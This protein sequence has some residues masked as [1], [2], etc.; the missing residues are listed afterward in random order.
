MKE[1]VLDK[2]NCKKERAIDSL[3]IPGYVYF[4]CLLWWYEMMRYLFANSF[5]VNFVCK[6]IP[7]GLASQ[8]HDI[9]K[10]IHADK[11]YWF[12][13]LKNKINQR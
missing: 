9:F 12:C 11:T 6:K 8:G 2:P 3:E 5:W 7:S 13:W 4:Y 1:I 10:W